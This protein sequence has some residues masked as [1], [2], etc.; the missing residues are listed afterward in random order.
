MTCVYS[1]PFLADLNVGLCT[2]FH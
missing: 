2:E 1:I